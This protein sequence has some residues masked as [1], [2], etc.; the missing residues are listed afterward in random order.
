MTKSQIYQSLIDEIDAHWTESWAGKA[1]PDWTL[2]KE[3][4]EWLIE[5][6]DHPGV[7]VEQFQQQ[8]ERLRKLYIP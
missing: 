1:A 3:I 4:D 6:K 8:A 7:S 5:T 2:F